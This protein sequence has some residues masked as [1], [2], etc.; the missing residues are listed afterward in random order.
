MQLGERTGGSK[1]QDNYY[2]TYGTPNK[3]EPEEEKI[4]QVSG[5]NRK[6]F[7]VKEKRRRGKK[8]V[9]RDTLSPNSNNRRPRSRSDAG[10]ESSSS[11]EESGEQLG[12]QVERLLVV[13]KK[14]RKLD[15][16][17]CRNRS[18]CKCSMCTYGEKNVDGKRRA[19][20]KIMDLDTL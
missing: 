1:K 7:F 2:K 11:D 4:V 10:I 16:S 13:E 12:Q 19:E 6:G 5:E 3:T 15:L 18:G 8:G 17:K 14:D 9:K 20:L